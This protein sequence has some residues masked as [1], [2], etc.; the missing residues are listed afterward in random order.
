MPPAYAPLQSGTR[1]HTGRTGACLDRRSAGSTPL[2]TARHDH[3]WIAL[4]K[5]ESSKRVGPISLRPSA[6]EILAHLCEHPSAQDTL[7]GIVEWWLLEQ[8]IRQLITE[9][10]AALRELV[11]ERLVLT[12]QG[13]EGHTYYRVNRSKLRA[14]RTLL[15]RHHLHATRSK[16]ESHEVLA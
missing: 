6:W 12:R 2:Q 14:I 4:I 11:A 3:C 5:A 7:E 15:D 1:S 8:K 13:S 9:T 16:P 10:R